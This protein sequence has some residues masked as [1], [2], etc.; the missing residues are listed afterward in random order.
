[1][2]RWIQVLLERRRARRMPGTNGESD[3]PADLHVTRSRAT[4]GRATDQA[5]SAASTGTGRSGTFVGRVAGEDP[6]DAPDTGDTGA[7]RRDQ[8]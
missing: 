6:G 3:V 2:L 4:G 8:R 5:D 1:M 7:E